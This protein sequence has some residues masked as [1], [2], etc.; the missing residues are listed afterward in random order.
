MD[1]GLKTAT[2][3]YG[4]IIISIEEGNKGDFP[5]IEKMQEDDIEICKYLIMELFKENAEDAK[6]V[7]LRI[8]NI[9]P[10]E[11]RKGGGKSAFYYSYNRESTKK[12]NPP[13]FVQ[14]YRIFLNDKAIEITLSYR[15]SEKKIWH[16]D[17]DEFIESI[18]FK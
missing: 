3:L 2:Y 7:G 6:K 14:V 18:V 16:T 9:T 5:A 15:Q 13:V 17:F 11:I 12:G 10:V 8:L 1:I 4:R